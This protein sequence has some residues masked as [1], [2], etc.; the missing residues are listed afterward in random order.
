M[1]ALARLALA[2]VTAETARIQAMS[3]CL[4]A[5][6]PTICDE[7]G[8]PTDGTAFE[9]DDEPL[10]VFCD[11]CGEREHPADMTPDWNGET[12]CHL[13]CEQ[14]RYRNGG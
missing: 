2:M 3:V 5:N 6:G 11:I 9:T 1:N 13:S 12:G 7:C 8:Q 14:V 4:D 10:H